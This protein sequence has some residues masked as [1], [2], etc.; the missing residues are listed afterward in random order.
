MKIGGIQKVSLIDFPGKISCVIFTQGCNFRC[1]YCHNPELVYPHL[2]KKEISYEIIFEYL[3]KRK[4][5]LEA[6]VITGGEPTIHSN[7][8]DFIKEIKKLGYDVKLDTNGSN[9]EMLEEVIPFVDYVAMDIKTW[10]DRIEYSK[11]CGVEIDIRKIVE[12]INLIVNSKKLF[13]FRTTV[14]GVIISQ[15]TTEKIRNFL[16]NKYGEG[17]IYKTQRMKMNKRF[18]GGYYA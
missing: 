16:K 7:I 15:D 18:K 6:V 13:E 9:P 2:F 11:I 17:I 3:K 14:D 8:L 10:F 12:S 5:L 4:G 1:R